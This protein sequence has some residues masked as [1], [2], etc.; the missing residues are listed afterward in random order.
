MK[1]KVEQH[2]DKQLLRRLRTGDPN[3]L[4]DAYRQYRVWLLVVATTYLTDE[5]EAKTLV[6]DFFIE[7]WDKNL[8]KDVR[9]P[10]R[11]FL[12]KTLTERCKK[13]GIQINMYP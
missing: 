10:L 2:N 8:F 3:A 11:T 5:A 6:E 1:R 9:V 13:Q 12:F 7:C 4:N